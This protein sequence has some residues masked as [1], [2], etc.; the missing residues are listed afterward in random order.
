MPALGQRGGDVP[1]DRRGG[2]ADRDPLPREPRRDGARAG[3]A[4]VQ[5]ERGG[6]GEERAE[7]APERPAHPD[8]L[9]QREAV[10]G[11]D[12]RGVDQDHRA[13]RDAAVIA[14]D[15]LGLAGGARRVRDAPGRARRDGEP[16]GVGGAPGVELLGVQHRRAGGPRE[17]A[18]ALPVG[19]VRDHE[20]RLAVG[21]DRG[22]ARVREVGIEGDVCL[23]GFEHAEDGG[24]DGRVVLEQ[25]RDRLAVRPARGE[26]GVRDPV[27][28]RRQRAVR[29]RAPRAP[30]P[31]ARPDRAGRARRT[32]R[33]SAGRT[34]R[35]GTR[36]R[37]R[38]GLARRRPS[39]VLLQAHVL[40]RRRPRVRVDHHQRRLGHP[41]P[42]RA[43]PDVLEDRRQAHALVDGLLDLVQDR[44]ALLP[45][46]LAACCL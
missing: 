44:L 3:G 27:R 39:S 1:E 18:S 25:E 36:A 26:D 15:S 40:E 30:A 14:D 6:A 45:V 29:D 24:Q 13:M 11:P 12:P 7:D 43:R 38:R 8:G 19:G 9:H 23:A 20:R 33:R 10:A 2:H 22:E 4:H 17:R 28:R 46:G 31:R 35:A 5:R 32:D 42:D 34:R 37:R 16:D 21:E 41:R